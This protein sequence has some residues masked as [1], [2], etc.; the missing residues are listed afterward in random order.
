MPAPILTRAAELAPLLPEGAP[1][2]GL[3]HGTRM[4][5]VAVSDSRRSIASPLTTLRRSRRLTPDLQAIEALAAA[6]GAA[7]F[8]LGLP[9]N[10]DGSEGARCDSVRSFAR[11]LAR[12]SPRPILLWDE[13]LSTVAAHAVLDATDAR[14]DRRRRLVDRL[15]AAHILADALEA[16]RRGAPDGSPERARGR[17]GSE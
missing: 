16:L 10:M 9:R 13:R 4:I 5:G 8:V 3:D 17:T 7:A 14:A 11:S 6:R 12:I 2:I 15:A 1:L